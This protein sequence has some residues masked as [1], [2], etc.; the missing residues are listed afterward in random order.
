MN[1]FTK[2]KQTC[3]LYKQAY[4]GQRGQVRGRGGAGVWDWHR[5]TMYMEW[6]GKSLYGDLPY[7]MGNSTQQFVITIWEKNLKKNLHVYM[8]N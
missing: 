8:Y 4:G 6:M 7:S 2:Q 3:R 5:H 1:L